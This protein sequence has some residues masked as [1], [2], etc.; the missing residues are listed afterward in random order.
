MLLL[1]G[2]LSACSNEE[3]FTP[4]TPQPGSGA[5]ELTVSAG[6]FVTDGAPLTRAADNGNVTTFDRSDRIGLIILK[7]NGADLVADNV[8]YTYNGTSW[9]FDTSNGEGKAA[10]YYD[11][12]I[13]NVTYIAYFPY[14]K[15][16]DGIKT[17]NELKNKFVPKSDQRS[18]ADYR[19]S[20]LLVW[21]SGAASVPQKMLDIAL[22]HAYASISLSPEVKCTLADGSTFSYIPS[23]VSDV[24]FTVGSDVYLPFQAEDGS[25]RCILPAGT[26]GTVRWFYTFGGETYGSSR[27]LSGG[28]SENTRYVRQETIEDKGEYGLDMAQAGDFYCKNGSGEGYLIPGDAPLTAAQQAACIGI[29]YSTDASR[30]GEAAKKV[31]TDQGVTPHGLV[32]ALTNASEGCRWGN[33]NKDENSSGNVG[34]PFK[35]NTNQLLKQYSNIDGYGETRWIIDTYK[36]SGTTLQDTYSAFYHASRY[37]TAD[38]NTDKYATPS[39]TTGWFIP[40][41]GQWWDILSNLGGIDL[42]SYRDKTDSYTSISSAAPTA[43][44]NMNKYLEKINDAMKFSTDTYFWSSSESLGYSACSVRFYSDGYLNLTSSYKDYSS[45]RVRCSFAF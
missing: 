12:G 7:N 43:V 27:D 4:E 34:E 35:E 8:P 22:A 13:E 11:N 37:G 17:L 44:S 9:A 3:I 33:E 42:S 24:S 40:S 10:A 32:M 2:L 1:V 14:S 26:S 36:D 18:E 5:I 29:V 41:M 38:S 6:D 30:I 20:D 21:E 28:V 39:N 16:A 19:A 45:N 25:F 31:L 23:G 15:E